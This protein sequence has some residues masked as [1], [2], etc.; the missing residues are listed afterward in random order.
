[1][2]LQSNCSRTK[3]IVLIAPVT[4]VSLPLR[5]LPFLLYSNFKNATL[6]TNHSKSYRYVLGV[7]RTGG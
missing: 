1:M 7:I 6:K 4:S 3:V 5:F 2:F